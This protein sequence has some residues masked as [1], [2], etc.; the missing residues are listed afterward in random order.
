MK[1]N[2]EKVEELVE[3]VDQVVFAYEERPAGGVAFGNEA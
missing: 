1:R 3:V 2:P